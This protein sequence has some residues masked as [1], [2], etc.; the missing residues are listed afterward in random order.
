LLAV[1]AVLSLTVAV[2]VNSPAVVG[3]PASTPTAEKVIPGGTVAGVVVQVYGPT[4][5][6][7]C[8]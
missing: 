7:T 6:L 4:P 1:A 8:N 3:I 5:P 2:K